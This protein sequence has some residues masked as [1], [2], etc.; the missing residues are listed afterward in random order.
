MFVK[1]KK[2]Q[3]FNIEDDGP[4]FKAALGQSGDLAAELNDH[5]VQKDT[6]NTKVINLVWLYTFKGKNN[7]NTL[8]VLRFNLPQGSI[9]QDQQG[10]K[11]WQNINR[12]CGD[13]TVMSPD[14][15]LSHSSKDCLWW[16]FPHLWAGC[17]WQQCC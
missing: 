17:T 13:C 1:K 3:T 10:L 16:P 12:V 15:E 9:S 11:P 7:N 4:A 14:R 8:I 5:R 2:L 6:L